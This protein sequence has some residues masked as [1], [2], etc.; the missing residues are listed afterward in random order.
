MTLAIYGD[1]LDGYMSEINRYPLLSVEEEFKVAVSYWKYKRIEDAHKLVTS[2]L[3]IVVKIA[4]GFRNYGCRLADLIQEGSIGLMKAVKKFN[5]H[6][7]FRLITYASWWIRSYIQDF[8]L[9]NK[10]LVKH[11]AKALKKNLFYKKDPA[12]AETEGITLKE[13]ITLFDALPA[14]EGPYGRKAEA[15]EGHPLED[16]SPELSLN[17]ECSNEKTTHLDLLKDDGAGPAEAMAEKQERRLAK[18]TVTTALAKLTPKERLVVEKR[19]LT[20]KPATLQALGVTLGVTRER[21]RQIEC[22]AMKKLKEVLSPQPA[23]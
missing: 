21:V 22:G 4:F 1:S 10:N 23:L 6:K 5:P 7:G 12:S 3:R 15:E 8:I 13:G 11:N 19:L 16:F 20:E 14:M 2:N 17:T 9:R 18:K